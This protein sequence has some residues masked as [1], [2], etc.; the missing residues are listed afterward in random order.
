MATRK[1]TGPK[2][3]DLRAVQIAKDDRTARDNKEAER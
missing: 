3:K 1:N 2:P